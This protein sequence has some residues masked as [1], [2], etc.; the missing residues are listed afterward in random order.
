LKILPGELESVTEGRTDNTFTKRLKL[1]SATDSN[2]LCDFFKLLVN[3]LSVLPS[4][5]DSNYPCGIF[6]LLVNVLSVLPS[7]TDSN[8]PC[9]IFKLLVNELKV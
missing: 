5:T 2:Y 3:V 9:G 6:K 8:Y 7:V 4:V 1:P